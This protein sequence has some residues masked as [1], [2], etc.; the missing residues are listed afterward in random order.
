MTDWLKSSAV[1]LCQKMGAE[2]L[3]RHRC[4]AAVTAHDP[5]AHSQGMANLRAVMAVSRI[6]F[7]VTWALPDLTFLHFPPPFVHPP[8]PSHKPLLAG[9]KAIPALIGFYSLACREKW[10]QRGLE[11]WG[12]R[13]I[14]YS[15]PGQMW[16]DKVMWINVS[17]TYR[18]RAGFRWL[19]GTARLLKH[20]DSRLVWFWSFVW[21]RIT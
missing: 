18:C 12:G 20:E 4:K 15:W 6:H 7:L 10:S 16:E 13:L 11:V 19:N 17:E 14:K 1:F 9:S 21:K 3:I 2:W 5:A 8:I